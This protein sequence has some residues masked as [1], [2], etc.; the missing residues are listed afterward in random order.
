MAEHLSRD[1]KGGEVKWALAGRSRERLEALR[2]ELSQTYGAE[3][4]DV[5][6]LTADLSGASRGVVA[7]CAAVLP[8]CAATWPACRW[9]RWPLSPCQSWC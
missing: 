4:K 6:I 2:L 1:Y 7:H 8:C 3:L 5:P 9:A